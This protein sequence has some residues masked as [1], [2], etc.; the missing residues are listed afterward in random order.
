MRWMWSLLVMAVGLAMLPAAFSEP[1]L[2][3]QL[4]LIVKV[5]S[6]RNRAAASSQ[7][8]IDTLSDATRKLVDEYRSVNSQIKDL[9]V[10]NEQL[11]KLVADQNEEIV[12]LQ[13]QIDTVIFVERRIMPLMLR[14]IETLDQFVRLDIPFLPDERRARVDNLHELMD[15]ADVSAAE[16]YRRLLEAY[17][18]ESEYGRTIEAY[19]GSLDFVD[20]SRS[21]DFLRL[22][23]VALYY[24]TLDA[25][26]SGM[27][28]V[29]NGA[30]VELS[31]KYRNSIR[32]GLRI[33]RKQAAP[34][35][36]HL[37][38]PAPQAAASEV[39]P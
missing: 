20:T 29:E 14:M 15:R 36:L 28:D 19:R 17:Q 8:K 38:I 23:R 32:Q 10:Y 13:R 11:Q 3:Q 39:A 34:D 1:A 27:W 2:A 6:E 16:K 37:P 7:V 25:S 24:Q 18:I 21:V 30:W 4:D 22:G 31:A 12:S 5:E 35:L 33:A 9:R 26:A